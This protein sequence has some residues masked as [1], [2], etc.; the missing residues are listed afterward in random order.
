MASD[1]GIMSYLEAGIRQEGLRQSAIAN[2]IANMSTP[3][4]RRVDV[5]FNEVLA[6]KM[7]DG[8]EISTE[9]MESE[10]IEPRTTALNEQGNDVSIDSE[11]G[12]LVKNSTNHKIYM[13]L[14]SKK[15]QQLSTAMDLAK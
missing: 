6:Q 9:D 2:N 10:I 7:A 12:D 14:L 1:V 4:Y 11:V 13:R 5:K 8:T 15:Y 3:G